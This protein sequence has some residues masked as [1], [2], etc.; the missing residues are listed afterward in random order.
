MQFFLP[1]E[2]WVVEYYNMRSHI[3]NDNYEVNPKLDL[4]LEIR[5]QILETSDKNVQFFNFMDMVK[6]KENRQE[7]LNTIRQR[8][9]LKG[10]E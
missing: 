6:G 8:V 2:N 3:K 5:K 9:G 4:S 10:E 7:L 1:N